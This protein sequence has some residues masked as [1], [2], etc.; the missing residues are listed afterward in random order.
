MTYFKDSEK[1]A[2]EMLAAR[3]RGSFLAEFMN[4]TSE[5]ILQPNQ[6]RFTVNYGRFFYQPNLMPGVQ[7]VEYLDEIERFKS[8]REMLSSYDPF[9]EI[10]GFGMDLPAEITTAWMQNLEDNVGGLNFE[11]LRGWGWRNY[12][13]GGKRAIKPVGLILVRSKAIGV[14]AE[15]MDSSETDEDDPSAMKILFIHSSRKVAPLGHF[16]HIQ[17]A[18]R[19]ENIPLTSSL[20][21]SGLY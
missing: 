21:P 18:G 15:L 7:S 12:M 6:K 13:E 5:E 8:Y 14:R 20:A 16:G 19:S 3:I 17:H 11:L 10:N 4:W 1:Q 2:I 9:I